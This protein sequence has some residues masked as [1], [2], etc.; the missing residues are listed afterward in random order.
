MLLRI[1]LIWHCHETIDHSWI[2]R[3]LKI[4]LSHFVN[5]IIVVSNNVKNHLVSGGVEPRKIV[6]V[7]NGISFDEAPLDHQKISKIIG[8]DASYDI[9]KMVTAVATFTENKGVHNVI[10]AL[11]KIKEA[12][13][14]LLGKI[15]F[16]VLGNRENNINHYVEHLDSLITENGLEGVVFFL[17]W[18]SNTLEV[19]RNVDICIVPSVHHEAFSLIA[20]EAMVASKIV[21]ASR[22]GGLSEVVIDKFN[23]F[24]FEA[25]DID[26]LANLIRYCV[27]NIASLGEIRQHAY[28]SA[29]KRFTMDRMISKI[30]VVYQSVL[31]K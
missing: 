8:V 13:P 20:A 18:V 12:D 22:T 3:K 10:K 7:Y 1:P 27:K 5:A 30:K 24:S 17:G 29:T 25:S 28:E 11:A 9:V 6:V 21:I 23:G 26:G 16:Y 14:D 19:I 31:A 4:F 15:R 2:E